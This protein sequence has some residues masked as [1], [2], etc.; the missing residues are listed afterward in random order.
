MRTIYATHGSESFNRRMDDAVNRIGSD[1]EQV[2]GSNLVA[3]ILG[4][5]YGRGEGGVV[6]KDGQEYP[7]NNLDFNLVVKHKTTVFWGKLNAV[8]APYEKEL[9]VDIHFGRPPLTVRYIENWPPWLMWYDLLNG[10]KVIEGPPNILTSHAPESVKAPLPAIEATRLA[11]NRGAGLL[12]ALRVA[13]GLESGTTPGFIQRS[14]NQCILGMGDALLIAHQRFATPYRV[15]DDRLTRL[16]RDSPEAA[17][18]RLS[19]LYQNALRFRLQP[20]ALSKKPMDEHLLKEL[21]R[22]WGG[23]FL[24]VEMIRTERRWS[25][26]SEYVRWPGLREK[27]QHALKKLPRNLIQNERLKIYSWKYPREALYRQLPVLLG[28]TDSHVPDWPGDS[29]R[30]LHIWDRFNHKPVFGDAS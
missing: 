2:L 17:M 20:D 1:V 19:P 14:C 26:L 13:R 15:R 8:R 4:G 28:V 18:F 24:H 30:F 29:A 21:A 25:S 9:H 3:F 7:C 23:I 11:L 10:H 5:S 22:R 12:R 16:E 27:E 6:R